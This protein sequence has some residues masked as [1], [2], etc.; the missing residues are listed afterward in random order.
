MI[1]EEFGIANISAERYE[2]DTL[3]IDTVGV[4]IGPF[5]MIDW[6][7][8]PYSEALHLVERY[9]LLDYEATKEAIARDAKEHAQSTNPG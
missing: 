7:G 5:S 3:V 1:A 4:K 6:Y 8:T 9:R 2:G